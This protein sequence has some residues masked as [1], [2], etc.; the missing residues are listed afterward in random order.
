[1][2]A[3]SDDGSAGDA[4][5]RTI[6]TAYSQYRRADSRIAQRVTEALGSA[7]TVLNVGAG[8]GSY[9][10]SDRAVTAA[11][12]SNVIM[13]MLEGIAPQ[14]QWGA[15]GSFANTLSDE[16]IADVT[17][18]VRTAWGNDAQPNATP[19]GVT[20]LRKYAA[21]EPSSSAISS[22]T[23][24]HALLCPNLDD[25]VIKP[26][27]AAG[28][29]S[30]EKAAVN[31]GS[32]VTLIRGYQSAVPKATRADVVE[33]LST[34]YCRLLADKPI[35]EAQMSAQISD[36]AQRVAAGLGDGKPM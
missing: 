1:M 33:A 4:D 26:A 23:I 15:M 28:A 16:Q 12:P 2:V 14:G 36:F 35:S 27:L 17:N 13:A 29:V 20:S 3:R 32:M 31:R 7:Q 30:L 10:P 9:E 21:T 18:Y 34:A 19:W 8:A 6:G 5:Y 11:E 25:G 22:R 24:T